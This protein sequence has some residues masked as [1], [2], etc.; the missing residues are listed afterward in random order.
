MYI[1]MTCARAIRLLRKYEQAKKEAFA[2]EYSRV[3]SFR[4]SELNI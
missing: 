1:V 3:H 4:H 2:I